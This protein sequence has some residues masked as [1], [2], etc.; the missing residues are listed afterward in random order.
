MNRRAQIWDWAALPL[1]VKEGPWRV[2]RL[3]SSGLIELS[4]GVVL[5][6]TPAEAQHEHGTDHLLYTFR[7]KAKA[8]CGDRSFDMTPGTTLFI[9]VGAPHCVSY[10]A[11]WEGLQ[12][13][14]AAPGGF[15]LR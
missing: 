1:S 3:P 4:H 14:L 13:N 2:K 8:T 12:I 15:G 9:P 10:E 11:G 5:S 7:G 6:D